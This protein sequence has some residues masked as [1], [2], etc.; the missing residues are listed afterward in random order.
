MDFLG[1]KKILEM[2]PTELA[3]LESTSTIDFEKNPEK[4]KETQIRVKSY[5][6]LNFLHHLLL[7]VFYYL[8]FMFQSMLRNSL[9]ENWWAPVGRTTFKKNLLVFIC[10]YDLCSQNDCPYAVSHGKP[11]HSQEKI[12]K[13]RHSPQ[14]D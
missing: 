9:S 3:E 1:L 13:T 11:H 8:K 12:S 6:S 7:Q 2:G 4:S 5:D 10:S 14:S